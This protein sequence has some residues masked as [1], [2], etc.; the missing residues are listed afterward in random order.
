MEREIKSWEGIKD[1]QF[2]SKQEALNKW[3][4]EW[5]DKKYLLEGY[6][7]HNNPLPDSFHITVQKPEYVDGIVDKASALTS[8]EKVQYSRD[9]VNT[10]T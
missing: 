7:A 8:V 6:H 9:V 2:I 4:E 1:Y 5:G 10:I 3:K